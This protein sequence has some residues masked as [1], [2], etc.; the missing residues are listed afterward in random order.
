M[1]EVQVN[2]ALV[3]VDKIQ[4]TESHVLKQDVSGQPETEEP[5]PSM[6]IILKF[7]VRSLLDLQK[8]TLFENAISRPYFDIF[9]FAK[10]QL[11]ADVPNSALLLHGY[12]LYRNDRQ[13]TETQKK[14]GLGGVSIAAR[15][16]K[17]QKSS[18]VVS[19]K[20]DALAVQLMSKKSSDLFC[21]LYKAPAPSAYKWA[22]VEL[23]CL[24]DELEGT[25]QEKNS[26]FKITGDLNFADTEWETTS[27]KTPH[28]GEI[29][30]KRIEINM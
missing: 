23:V 28:A 21:C 19:K 13:A 10:P 7:N 30:E 3:T 2:N 1:V 4:S 11:A 5:W 20:S 12:L 15:H 16:S 17:M 8:R 26:H 6:F 27:S 9:C 18:H 22:T 25:R 14:T 24:L 29:L